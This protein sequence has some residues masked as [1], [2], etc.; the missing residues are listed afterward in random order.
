[1]NCMVIFKRL[2][3]VALIVGL[4][5]FNSNAQP[6]YFGDSENST[7]GIEIRRPNFEYSSAS[8]S[9]FFINLDARVS[10]KARLLFEVP[11]TFSSANYYYNDVNSQSQNSIGN[12]FFGVRTTPAN[13]PTYFEGGIRFPTAPDNKTGSLYYGS[14]SDYPR[15]D[16][17]INDYFVVKGAFGYKSRNKSGLTGRFKIGPSFWLDTSD[18]GPGS[19]DENEFLVNYSGHLFYLGEV[20]NF[21]GGLSG[22]SILTEDQD[23]TEMLLDISVSFNT[24]R[25]RPGFEIHFPMTDV[26]DKFVDYVIGLGI[27][28]ELQ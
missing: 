10:D 6:L 7:I 23:Q 8:N 14:F 18:N 15:L 1:M 16:A 24:D 2:F 11:V 25:I 17:F 4:P 20:V 9:T 28:I 5:L 19:R 21:G 12:L 3:T 13:A 27:E 26:L 22:L